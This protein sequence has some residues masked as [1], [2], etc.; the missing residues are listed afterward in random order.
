MQQALD[1]VIG[2]KAKKV[3]IINVNHDGN[4]GYYSLGLTREQAAELLLKA[5]ENE[6]LIPRVTELIAPEI[7]HRTFSKALPD[8]MMTEALRRTLRD[9]DIIET[10]RIQELDNKV[11][12]YLS[13]NEKVIKVKNAGIDLRWKSSNDKRC[14][15]LH[16]NDESVY[17]HDELLGLI[18]TFKSKPK[19]MRDLLDAEKRVAEINEQLTD[20]SNRTET[21]IEYIKTLVAV[22]SMNFKEQNPLL[23]KENR[24]DNNWLDVNHQS[25]IADALSYL[26]QANLV[27]IN[28]RADDP[29]R[30]L[31]QIVHE[32]RM[33][34]AK[35]T[36]ILILDG[37]LYMRG[38][39]LDA[40]A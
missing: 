15:I 34:G 30:T 36:L 24:L 16:D 39:V 12:W 11:K 37:N 40:H 13:K 4:C 17:T 2:G 1:C 28:G 35:K 32:Y 19:I 8:A 5:L 18:N 10:E 20:F 26:M 25:G 3:R 7:K 14:T 27:V 6:E 23:M 33:E 29:A 22:S 38:E 31:G 9:K 21:V